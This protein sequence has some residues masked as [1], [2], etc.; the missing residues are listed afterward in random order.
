MSKMHDSMISTPTFD[1]SDNNTHWYRFQLSHTHTTFS[2]HVRFAS[3]HKLITICERTEQWE[4]WFGCR[5][6]NTALLYITCIEIN[7]YHNVTC[8][9]IMSTF[10]R[11]RVEIKIELIVCQQRWITNNNRKKKRCQRRPIYYDDIVDNATNPNESAGSK[12]KC[13]SAFCLLI[14]NRIIYPNQ[15]QCVMSSTDP[16][17][18]KQKPIIWQFKYLIK[19]WF[20]LKPNGISIIVVK[21]PAAFGPSNFN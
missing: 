14:H 10:I 13:N 12:L 7:P 2:Q 1:L 15:W 8:F 16:C 4:K 21:Y 18:L 9:I 19:F 17:C 3:E 6:T 20:T 11:Y 5:I